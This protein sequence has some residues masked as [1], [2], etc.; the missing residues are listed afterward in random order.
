M[1][2][3]IETLTGFAAIMLMLSLLVKTLTSV[4]KNQWDYYSDNLEHEVKRLVLQTT[5]KTWDAILENPATSPQIKSIA[6]DIHWERLG[7]EFLTPAHL[8][9]FLK[10]LDA[11]ARI[12][13]LES[14]LKIHMANVKYTFQMRM[15]NLAMAAGV[16]LCLLCNIN[17]FTIWKS[18]YTDQ[19]LR[20]TFSGSYADK[21]TKLADAQAGGSSPATPAKPADPTKP[22]DEPNTKPTKSELDAQLKGFRENM[23]GFLTDVSFG[24]GRIW[25][26]ECM[27]LNDNERRACQKEQREKAAKVKYY[28]RCVLYCQA[29]AAAQ[30]LDSGKQKP[31]KDAVDATWAAEE[32]A[33]TE[34]NL[35]E[36]AKKAQSAPGILMYE[37]FGCLLT[38][39]LVSIG[40]PYWHDILQALSS[41]RST[42]APAKAKV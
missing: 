7:E 32:K 21:A 28:S 13:N 31:A 24:V 36:D 25:R 42:P 26:E 35:A 5:G 14:R 18:L 34:F 30:K 17:A 38:G 16:G 4:I 8:S 40:A 20:A 27:I 10:E 33:E 39:I 1:L 2:S 22:A 41:L 11:N 37:F 9:W 29:L 19:Q 3:L 6:K 15:K 23:Q 12:N